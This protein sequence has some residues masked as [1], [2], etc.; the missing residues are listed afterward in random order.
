MPFFGVTVNVTLHVPFFNAFTEL[1]DTL[2]T[3]EDEPATLPPSRAPAGTAT[4]YRLAM[5]R[6]VVDLPTRSS[7]VCATG[8]TTAPEPDI[9][10]ATVVAVETVVAGTDAGVLTAVVGGEI[11]VVGVEFDEPVTVA[12][13][14]TYPCREDSTVM[15]AD[16]STLNPPALTTPFAIVA[17]PLITLNFQSELKLEILAVKPPLRG[18]A[19]SNVGGIALPSALPVTVSDALTQDPHDTVTVTVEF[20]PTA[21]P[22]TTARPM[23]WLAHVTDPAVDENEYVRSGS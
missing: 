19:G 18:T 7:G 22:L 17:L 15:V 23:F 16:W 6:K 8:A 5:T 2:H 21:R 14:V 12:V 11:V 3:L 1:P 9:A 20:C 10:T 4:L 13:D